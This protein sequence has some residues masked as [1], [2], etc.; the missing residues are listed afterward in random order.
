MPEASHIAVLCVWE[1][2][3]CSVQQHMEELINSHLRTLRAKQPFLNLDWKLYPRRN[4]PNVSSFLLIEGQQPA[5]GVGKG[6]LAEDGADTISLQR[7]HSELCVTFYNNAWLSSVLSHTPL[8]HM[9]KCTRRAMW[10][11]MFSF[12]LSQTEVTTFCCI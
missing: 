2:T 12:L 5:G 1:D 7:V 4:V 11:Q 9:K 6:L 8:T 3:A 10:M